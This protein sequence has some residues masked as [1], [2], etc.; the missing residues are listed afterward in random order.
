MRSGG[1]YGVLPAGGRRSD[2]ELEFA[3]RCLANLPPQVERP[4]QLQIL[5]GE[6]PPVPLREISPQPLEKLLTIPRSRLAALLKLDQTTAYLPMRRGKHCVYG[7]RRGPS[8][9]IE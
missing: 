3:R 6:T 8:G 4:H 5:A 2:P 1:R 9:L 7:A